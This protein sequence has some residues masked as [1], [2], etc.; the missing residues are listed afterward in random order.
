MICGLPKAI[1]NETVPRLLGPS[2]SWSV[3]EIVPPQ[4]TY[5]QSFDSV[6]APTLPP[7]WGSSPAGIWVT[8]TSQR[9]TVPN[10]AFAPDVSSV[11][12]Y[13][14]ISPVISIHSA[15]AELD[16]RHYY[17]TEPGYD[18]GVLEISIQ[19]GAFVDIAAAGGSFLSGGYNGTISSSYSNPLA[20]RS[21]WTG[22]SGGFVTT[23]VALPAAAN[24]GDIQLRWRLGNDSSV[25]ATGW[26][27][28]TLTVNEGYACCTGA[29]QPS[30]SA[31][32]YN[33]ADHTFQFSVT[34]GAGYSYAVLASTNLSNWVALST[35]TSP[36]T[37]VD[38]NA[39]TFPGRFYRTRYP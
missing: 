25:S 3:G 5:I 4:V 7:G 29:P 17:N 8:T 22:S 20:G 30:L 37:L 14:L 11:T 9:D 16:F 2:S 12:D 39:A 34:G 31:P 28:D 1:G 32:H 38:S 18:G 6:T 10:S 15:N 27:V 13:Q 36:F 33:G 35:N 24:G 21:A 19:G 23:K 26:Y